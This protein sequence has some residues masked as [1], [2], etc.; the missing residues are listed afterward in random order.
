MRKLM[1]K[2]N[3]KG[4]PIDIIF[5]MITAFVVV[6]FFGLWIYGFDR[7]TDTL[8][9]VDS[10]GANVNITDAVERTFVQVNSAQQTWIPVLAYAII[11]ASGLSI[12]ISSF[13][14]KAHPVFFLVYL[15]VIIGAVIGSV[16]LANAYETQLNN[17]LYGS[18]LQ[19]MTGGSFIVLHLPV[20]VAV[21]GFLGAILLFIGFILDRGG[22]IGT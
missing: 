17:P 13:L 8:L 14:V 12:L 6:L 7:M 3:K 16:H 10:S 5:F 18:T 1:N 4:S 22:G 15:L 19:S 9:N 2:K 21:I 20:W 11:F